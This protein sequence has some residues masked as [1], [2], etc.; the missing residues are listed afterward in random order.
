MPGN[1]RR[2]GTTDPCAQRQNH[3]PAC[4]SAVSQGRDLARCLSVFKILFISLRQKEREHVQ[5]GTVGEGEADSSRS[6]EPDAGLSE[7]NLN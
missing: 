5:A 2:K 1:G 3:L 6:R 7:H 4:L